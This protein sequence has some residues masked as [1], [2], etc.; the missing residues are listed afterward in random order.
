MG[1]N[2]TSSVR[3]IWWTTAE[4]VTGLSAVASVAGPSHV[5]PLAPRVTSHYRDRTWSPGDALGGATRRAVSASDNPGP[6]VSD[7]CLLQT[8]HLLQD[9]VYVDPATP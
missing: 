2:K 1:M 3:N 4:C 5:V 8:E 6:Q 9:P 7:A